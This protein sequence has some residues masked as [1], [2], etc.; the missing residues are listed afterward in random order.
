MYGSDSSASEE[1][2]MKNSS[3]FADVFCI[4]YRDQY[5]IYLPLRG[6]IMLGNARLVNLL[7]QARLGDKT[8]LKQLGV[9]ESLVSDL[10]ESEKMLKRL[11]RPKKIPTFEPVSVSL[12]LTNNCTLRCRYCYAEGGND[13]T[14]MS[15]DVVTGVLDQVLEN[16]VSSRSPHMTVHFHGGG[17]VSSAWSLFVRAREYLGE[18]T[19]PHSITVRTSVGLNGMLNPEQRKWVTQNIDNA[20]VSIDGPPDVQN[21]QRP[22]PD[23][24][25]SF[26][27]VSETIRAFDEANY[28][29][30][31]RSTITAESVSRMAEAVS[32]FC[33]HFKVQS[34]KVEPMYPRGRGATSQVRPPDAV[35]FV[36]GFREARAI[37]RD[38]GRDLIYS[39]A[40]LE[41]VTNVFCQAAGESC[42]ITPD[43]WITGCYEVLRPDDPLSD[44]FFYGRYDRQ[45]R[46]LIVD[47]ERRQRLFEL[48]VE[49]KPFCEK[50]FCK[51]HC[52]GDCPAKSSLA[53]GMLSPDSPDRCYINRELTKDQ[54]TEALNS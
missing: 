42:G 29:Y 39:G 24:G 22:R 48:S 45:S 36:E 9:D 37:A 50:C 3:L 19:A 40:R 47:D 2:K 23:G 8:A 21:F 54:I 15:W 32:Y 14:Q 41:V 17:D 20:T 38:A 34:I 26:P 4:P 25:P 33:E 31:I 18:I 49:H 7:Y 44:R 10:F 30:G 5:I 35:E 11:S 12:F 43:G 52:A 6:I 27:I 13:T 28:S 51:W 53:G 46:R 1:N 16:V